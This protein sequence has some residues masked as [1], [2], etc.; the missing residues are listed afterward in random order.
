MLSLLNDDNVFNNRL[1]IAMTNL[2]LPLGDAA[3]TIYTARLRTPRYSYS[4][5]CTHWNRCISRCHC[6][7]GGKI[8][9]VLKRTLEISVQR[10]PIAAK[11]RRGILDSKA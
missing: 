7:R 8:V 10:L 5:G 4:N 11:E 1:F 9:E 3:G 6:N 2:Y